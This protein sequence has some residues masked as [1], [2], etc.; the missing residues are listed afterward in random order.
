M[1]FL[2]AEWRDLLLLNYEVDAEV[3]AP[4]VPAGVELAD[5][6]GTMLASV[7]GFRF[8]DTK[9]MGF[10]VPFHR[11]FEEVNLRFYVRRKAGGSWRQGVV[12]VKEIVPKTAIAWLARRLYGEN[13]HRHHMRHRISAGNGHQQTVEY[14]WL[15]HA[16]DERLGHL[17]ATRAGPLRQPD[18]GSEEA[19]L[20]EHYWGYSQKKGQ[21][22]E[23]RVDHP[24]WQVQPVTE[25]AF[26]ADV[27]KVYGEAFAEALSGDPHSAFYAEGSGVDVYSAR[28]LS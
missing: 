22:C 10:P 6:N 12:F 1:P 14:W 25:A 3:L 5:Y 24:P 28:P 18:E 27:A 17:I 23:Y 2:T 13:Y 8:L 20:V 15:P 16:H 21:T 26:D 9:M 19:F 11:N 4:Y 7:V